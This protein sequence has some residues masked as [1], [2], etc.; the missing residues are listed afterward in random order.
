[1]LIINVLD[2]TLSNVGSEVVDSSE[3]ASKPKYMKYILLTLTLLSLSLSPTFA[4][5]GSCGTGDSSHSVSNNHSTTTKPKK[6][7]HCGNPEGSDACKK[8]C[9]TN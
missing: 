5:C 2:G 3:L 1:M 7:T 6:C 8:A 9:K 4:H